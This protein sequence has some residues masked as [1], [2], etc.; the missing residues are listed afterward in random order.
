V[1]GDKE[2]HYPQQRRTTSSWF[3]IRLKDV[4]QVA[5]Q[6]EQAHKRFVASGYHSDW[7]EAREELLYGRFHHFVQLNMRGWDKMFLLG[8]CTLYRECAGVAGEHNLAMINK[9]R[10]LKYLVNNKQVDVQYVRLQHIVS[11]IALAPHIEGIKKVG[12]AGRQGEINKTD[13]LFVLP[14]RH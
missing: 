5:W 13:K 9:E 6:E 8:S 12:D 7:K 2:D 1:S 10:P 4:P 14:I 11:P 3:S